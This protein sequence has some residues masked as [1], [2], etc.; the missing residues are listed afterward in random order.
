MRVPEGD[1]RRTQN[2]KVSWMKSPVFHAAHRS[3][4]DLSSVVVV[5]FGS[6]PNGRPCEWENA[7]LAMDDGLVE[8]K[9]GT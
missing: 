7:L 9:E 8:E 1:T 2:N 6:C 5:F 4:C 3:C